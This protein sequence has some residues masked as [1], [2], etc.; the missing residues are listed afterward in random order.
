MVDA[1]PDTQKRLPNLIGRMLHP[2]VLAVP[3]LLI[4]LSDLG[5]QSAIQWSALTL[6]ILLV[7]GTLLVIYLRTLGRHT[8]QR[9]TRTPLYVT[10]WCSVVA[11]ALLTAALDAPRV[12][13]ACLVALAV[14]LPIQLAF[15]TYLTKI[16]THAAVAAGCM[17][18]LFVLGK[19]PNLPLQLLGIGIVL[20]VS[21][22]RIED[23][24]HT[25]TQVVLGVLVG[26]GT[27]LLVF[28]FVLNS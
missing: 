17:T 23:R 7:P 1:A 12:L 15:N 5:W 18:G 22:A 4:V 24:N 16:S 11:A 28:P 13:I 9:R 6:P 19:L 20:A 3:T 10:A 25:F 14:W 27:V 21:W 8:Y 26:T 2:A